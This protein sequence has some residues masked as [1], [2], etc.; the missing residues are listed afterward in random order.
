M[1]V[2]L[3]FAVVFAFCLGGVLSMAL[4]PSLSK[5]ASQAQP[6]YGQAA[7]FSVLE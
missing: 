6:Y 5:R 3:F 2:R 4:D 7:G 1:L